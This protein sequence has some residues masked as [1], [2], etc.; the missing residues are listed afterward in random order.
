VK[1]RLIINTSSKTVAKVPVI[2]SLFDAIPGSASD[3][4]KDHVSGQFTF[5]DPHRAKHTIKYLIVVPVWE[6]EGP[7]GTGL[8]LPFH[9]EPLFG[10]RIAI[11][12][13]SKREPA[14]IADWI[15]L[16]SKWP[17]ASQY[18]LVV[19]PTAYGLFVGLRGV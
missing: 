16:H 18:R 19:E 2:G 3:G 6:N 7:Q 14:Y 8:V 9:S 12:L 13:E 11:E 5:T 15:R 17:A 10:E 1:N 4:Q